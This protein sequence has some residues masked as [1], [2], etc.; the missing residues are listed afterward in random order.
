MATFATGG[1]GPERAV[2]SLGHA[3]AGA[4]QFAGALGLAKTS[5]VG[6]AVSEGIE[7]VGQ[8]GT[9]IQTTAEHTTHFV[10]TMNT[11]KETTGASMDALVGMHKA[12]SDVGV[13][14]DQVTVLMRNFALQQQSMRGELS[15]AADEEPLIQQRVQQA[16]VEAELNKRGA[17]LET[18]KTRRE[19]FESEQELMLKQRFAY[20]DEAQQ[21]DQSQFG[22]EQ[23]FQT[24]RE[25]QMNLRGAGIA[26]EFAP[27]RERMEREGADL[28]VSGAVIGVGGAQINLAEALLAQRRLHGEQPGQQEMRDLREWEVG[29]RVAGAQQGLAEAQLRQRQ[30]VLTDREVREREDE[31]LGPEDQAR[32]QYR[33]ARLGARGADIGLAGAQLSE[34]ERGARVSAGLGAQSQ[35]A[36][37]SEA[38]AQAQL[39]YAGAIA[40]VAEATTAA[41]QAG[42]RQKTIGYELPT[43][44]A[45]QI[46]TGQGGLDLNLVSPPVIGQATLQIGQDLGGGPF[47][48]IEALKTIQEQTG[49]ESPFYQ[50][51]IRQAANRAGVTLTPS[52][53]RF[54]TENSMARIRQLATGGNLPPELQTFARNIERAGPAAGGYERARAGAERGVLEQQVGDFPATS[55]GAAQAATFGGALSRLSSEIYG[56]AV[57]SDVNVG[58]GGISV[59][60]RPAAFGEEPQPEPQAQ[61]Q[62]FTRTFGPDRPSVTYGPPPIQ[63]VQQPA[64]PQIQFQGGG[65]GAPQAGGVIGALQGLGGAANAASSALHGLAGAARAGKGGGGTTTVEEAG[66]SDGGGGGGKNAEGGYITGPGDGTSDSIRA[67]WLSNGEYV[68]KASRVQTL[69]VPY[70]D[71]LN[72]GEGYASGGLIQQAVQ[73]GLQ[74]PRSQMEGMTDDEL[75]GALAAF[76]GVTPAEVGP[77]QGAAAMIGHAVGAAASAWVAAASARAPGQPASV[78]LPL[79]GPLMPDEP[80]ARPPPFEIGMTGATEPA[81]ARLPQVFGPG[82]LPPGWTRSADG[83][84]TKA[85]DAGQPSG[86]LASDPSETHALYPYQTTREAQEHF[87]MLARGNKEVSE[88]LASGAATMAWVRT[89]RGMAMTEIDLRPRNA[90]GQVR[91]RVPGEP[92][93]SGAH[94]AGPQRPR[95]ISGE[96]DMAYRYGPD[97]RSLPWSNDQGALARRYPGDQRP[98]VD[99]GVIRSAIV[100]GTQIVGPPV[101]FPPTP[102]QVMEGYHRDAYGPEPFAVYNKEGYVVGGTGRVVEPVPFARFD[103]YGNPLGDFG[104]LDANRMPTQPDWVRARDEEARRYRDPQSE[105]AAASDREVARS[106][107]VRGTQLYGPP[108]PFPPT[109]A[110]VMKG[111]HTDPALDDPNFLSAARSLYDAARREREV[112]EQGYASGGEVGRLGTIGY[113]E[114]GE[115][116][117]L[118][119]PSSDPWPKDYEGFH[120]PNPTPPSH[121]HI[122][123]PQMSPRPQPQRQTQALPDEMRASSR[124]LGRRREDGQDPGYAGGGRVPWLSNGEYVMGRSAVARFGSGFFDG[125]N[126]GYQTGGLVGAPPTGATTPVPAN[127]PGLTQAMTSSSPSLDIAYAEMTSPLPAATSLPQGESSLGVTGQSYLS[128]VQAQ[129]AQAMRGVMGN[130]MG[131]LPYAL[132]PLPGTSQFTPGYSGALMSLSGTMGSQ[133][134]PSPIHTLN[135]QTDA[136]QFEMWSSQQ[137]IEAI[138]GSSL[139]T[140]MTQTGVKPSWFS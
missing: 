11:M 54:F 56:W 128:L 115:V 132:P 77:P 41:E 117:D 105:Q 133:A 51:A 19:A 136:G 69:G 97:W 30:A 109:P 73:V 104:R 113:Q 95:M 100:R 35:V 42:L 118:S 17:V 76:L 8:V 134:G 129:S 71:R 59:G 93:L 131:V 15:R 47:S 40:K 102:E 83:R 119:T 38:A 112:R 10:N 86:V 80:S 34:E 107:T 3:T 121:W 2:E 99:P 66:P 82:Y 57:E 50:A 46:E 96:D 116:Q 84:I 127:T 4:A 33:R 7:A 13:Q 1:G 98:L 31:G 65:G 64:Q 58:P 22:V 21:R 85:P 62:P 94:I 55:T 87:D 45:R 16:V 70:L 125:L 12:F 74:I 48:Q 90:P 106:A 23:A 52:L 91:E 110:Q 120:P 139:S 26:L 61:P 114:G 78:D 27:Q 79:R 36:Q 111:Y 32:E 108:I 5:L 68:I 137:T 101:P 92:F 44:V 130:Q 49:A 89:S 43:A 28:A 138:Q 14:T 63:P 20:R 72:Q 124:Y 122:V 18:Q 88:E 6:F 123:P 25:A 67:P 103:R 24:R 37:A 39:A 75:R 9:A 140:R 135:L 53:T 81:P 60:R 126:A 29:Q